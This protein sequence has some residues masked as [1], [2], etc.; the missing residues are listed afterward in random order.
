MFFMFLWAWPSWGK[1]IKLLLY[2]QRKMFRFLISPLSV[3]VFHSLSFVCVLLQTLHMSA[4]LSATW[5]ITSR[6]SHRHLMRSTWTRTPM[7]DSPYSPSVPTTGMKVSVTEQNAGTCVCDFESGRCA[8]QN[9]SYGQ[10]YCW[11]ISLP[12][13]SKTTFCSLLCLTLVYWK[14]IQK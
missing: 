2:R 1:V 5:T 6:R 3:C 9:S 7:L 10:I 8:K 14:K 11:S 13:H 12:C 4:F